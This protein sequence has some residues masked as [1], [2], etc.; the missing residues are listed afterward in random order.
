[1]LNEELMH[2]SNLFTMRVPIIT[3]ILIEKTNRGILRAPF[4]LKTVI[5]FKNFV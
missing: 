4:S 2:M 3:R 5:M 1:M